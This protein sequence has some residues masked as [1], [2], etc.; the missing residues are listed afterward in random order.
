MLKKFIFLSFLML[1]C[2][3]YSQQIKTI[4]LKQLGQNNFSTIVPLGQPLELSF[5]D[6]EADQ[7]AYSYKIEQM[8]FDWKPSDLSTNEYIEGFDQNTIQNYEN[9]FNTLQ[10]Y[11]HYKVQIPNTTTKITKSGNY[12]ISVLDENEEV[13]F[14]RRFTLYESIATVGLSVTR[15]KDPKTRNQQQT[16]KF[17][18]HHATIKINNPAQEIKIAVLQ[19]NNWQTAIS[20]LKPQ[21]YKNNL[22][23]Y[24]Y[25]KK[26]NFWGGNEFLNF[27]NKAIRN[28]N[29]QIAKVIRKDLYHHYLYPQEIRATKPYTYNPDINGHFVVRGLEGNN[30]ENEADYVSVHFA[31]ETAKLEHKQVYMYGAFN[32]FEVNETTEMQYDT[33]QKM[34]VGNLLFK[35]G[36]YNYRF[37]TKNLD[38]SLDFNEIG[39]SFYQTENEYTVLVYYKAFGDRYDRVIGIGNSFF[40]QQQ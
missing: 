4:Q 3:T 26:S 18:V 12:V 31:L 11:T 39:G 9:S 19:N 1:I 23:E 35:Q 20:H 32:N 27:D 30:S 7:K 28:T 10:S 33:I 40:N 14:S 16:V 22:L 29:L 25:I 24:R 8:N 21:F 5:D 2:V 17:S 13:V 37:V 38:N 36:F 34:Y 15:S 6:L